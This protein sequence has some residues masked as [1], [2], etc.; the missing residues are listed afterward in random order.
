MKRR[1]KPMDQ[2]KR[3]FADCPNCTASF[4]AEKEI[5]TQKR[6]SCGQLLTWNDQDRL[7]TF[8]GK[9]ETHVL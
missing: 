1:K 8:Y 7:K 5:D 9:R 6:C 2:R 3:F 4:E